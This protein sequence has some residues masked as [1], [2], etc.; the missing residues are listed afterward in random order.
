MACVGNGRPE[1]VVPRDL[2]TE[3]L[4]GLRERHADSVN[5]TRASRRRGR[6][7]KSTSHR[8]EH[9]RTNLVARR[10]ASN[11]AA[12]IHR[13]GPLERELD[14]RT[15]A[16]AIFQA[17][18]QERESALN[19]KLMQTRHY[20]GDGKSDLRG[21]MTASTKRTGVITSRP[22]LSDADERPRKR[23]RGGGLP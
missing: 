8:H 14:L 10:L 17:R 16:A 2:P 5:A 18:L 1:S 23:Q 7:H 6:A 13:H 12:Q 20:D 19:R 4:P 11:R 15:D 9:G 3:R 22:T 21:A